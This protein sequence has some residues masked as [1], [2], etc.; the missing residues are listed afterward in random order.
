MKLSTMFQKYI[1][2]TKSSSSLDNYKFVK[3]HSSIIINSLQSLNTIELPELTI[4]KLHELIDTYKS[5]GNSINTINKRV[6]IIKRMLKHNHISIQ[7]ISDFP[8]IPFKRKSFRI[9]PEAELKIAINYFRSLDD[10]PCN[11]QKKIMFFMFLYTG[12]RL[13]E[14]INIRIR[15]IDFENHAILL[16]HTKTGDPRVVFFNPLEDPQFDQQLKRYIELKQR[17]LLFWNFRSYINQP[18]STEHVEAMFF[19]VKKILGLSTLRPH[20]L[21]HTMATLLVEN[22]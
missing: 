18:F 7:G 12:A 22:G 8:K 9:V 2:H 13:K 14:L 16:D 19:Y 5:K 10:S 11:L 20:N 1:N 21:R 17:D 6:G 4:D 3:V 15:N